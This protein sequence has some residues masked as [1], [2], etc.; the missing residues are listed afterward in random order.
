MIIKPDVS[1]ESERRVVEKTSCVTVVEGNNVIASFVGPNAKENA[2]VFALLANAAEPKPKATC[3]YCAVM[4]DDDEV[5]K[6]QPVAVQEAPAGWEELLRQSEDN[7]NRQ[8]GTSAF[9]RWIYTNLDELFSASTAPAVQNGPPNHPDVDLS[10]FLAQAANSMT[11]QAAKVTESIYSGKSH[12]IPLAL[13]QH[14]ER[15]GNAQYMVVMKSS[16][17]NTDFDDYNNAPCLDKDEGPAFV[18]AWCRYRSELEAPTLMDLVSTAPT[19]QEAAHL[20]AELKE[21]TAKSP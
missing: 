7:F 17:Y 3:A 16:T 4:V 19:A 6:P 14:I 13:V 8:F 2:E 11:E 21:D 10:G 18:A 15:R 20:L 9:S 12:T 1:V 5:F